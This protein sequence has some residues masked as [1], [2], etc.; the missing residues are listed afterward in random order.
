M[1]FADWFISFHALCWLFHIA[2]GTLLISSYRFRPFDDWL[3]SFH[4]NCWLVH[5]VS[6]P[7]LI[8]SYRFIPFADWFISFQ[9]LFW[10][11]YIISG[12][13]ILPNEAGC[14]WLRWCGQDDA[15]EDADEDED[16][17][18]RGSS[19]C[20]GGRK[21]LGVRFR[22]FCHVFVSL[23]VRS[24]NSVIC[25]FPGALKLNKPCQADTGIKP[26]AAKTSLRIPHYGQELPIPLMF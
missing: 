13:E 19:H 20:G 15:P 10:L 22:H 14:C 3:I 11:V 21:G 26:R 16:E 1:P 12:P 2:S 6:G 25:L 23:C 4:S 17:E 7:L 24:S 18:E 9:V 8:G 5:I